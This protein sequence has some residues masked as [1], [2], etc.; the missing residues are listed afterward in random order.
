M[1]QPNTNIPPQQ[2]PFQLVNP[3]VNQEPVIEVQPGVLP[4][5]Q[6]APMQPQQGPAPVPQFQSQQ[7]QK[8]RVTLPDGQYKFQ[9]SKSKVQYNVPDRF[10]GGTKNQ[11]EL[12]LD[13]FPTNG[14]EPAQSRMWLNI[15]QSMFY[16]DTKTNPT[17]I[18]QV[19]LALG[20]PVTDAQRDYVINN[21]A[22]LFNGMTG[23]AQFTN[24]DKGYLNT[25]PRQVV[26]L[27]AVDPLTG[28]SKPLSGME[29]VVEENLKRFNLP[30]QSAPVYVTN[31]S[32]F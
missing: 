4:F 6:P 11:V 9:I 25:R 22:T 7:Q 27:V 21:I 10:N 30:A 24:S 13:I 19:L 1:I 31:P 16:G 32:P 8:P 26:S 23:Y 17:Q 3:P 20:I 15:T 18:A 29:Q 12:S 28:Q 5:Q 2:H 14:G